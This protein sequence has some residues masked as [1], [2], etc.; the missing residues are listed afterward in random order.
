MFIYRSGYNN[1]YSGSYY[2]YNYRPSN[3]RNIKD[4]LCTNNNSYDGIVYDKFYCP[5]EGFSEKET[6]CCGLPGDQFCCNPSEKKYYGN[7]EDPMDAGNWFLVI[8]LILVC[9]LVVWGIIHCMLNFFKKRKQDSDDGD[10]E[11]LTNNRITE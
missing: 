11:G 8:C 10:T 6:A 3:Y 4:D 1:Y 7:K 2:G 9:G 5:I